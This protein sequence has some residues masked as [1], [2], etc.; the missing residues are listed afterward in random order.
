MLRIQGHDSLGGPRKDEHPCLFQ[1]MIHMCQY[2]D[3]Y[4]TV[5]T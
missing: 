1:H 4:T 5:N 2:K 3:L